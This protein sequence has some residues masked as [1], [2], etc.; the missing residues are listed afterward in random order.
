MPNQFLSRF[1]YEGQIDYSSLPGFKEKSYDF[2]K[3]LLT[4]K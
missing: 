3:R 1:L 2:M 4:V